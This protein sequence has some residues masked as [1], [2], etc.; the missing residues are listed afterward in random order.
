MQR[1]SPSRSMWAH[2]VPLAFETTVRC[3]PLARRLSRAGRTPSGTTSH[4]FR[5]LLRQRNAGFCEDEVEVQ[6]ATPG[7]VRAADRLAGIDPPFGQRVGGG[8]R[9]R[10]DVNAMSRQR[11]ADPRPVGKHEYAAGIQ[12]HGFESHEARL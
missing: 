1:A 6:P 12:E 7:V 3:R 5:C 4:R 8:Q 9:L 10:I 2:N 11:V